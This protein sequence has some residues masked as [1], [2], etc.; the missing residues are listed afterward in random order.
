MLKL[1]SVSFSYEYGSELFSVRTSRSIANDL[2]SLNI[3]TDGNVFSASVKTADEITITDLSAVFEFEFKEEDRIFLNGYQS[4]TD[5]A[6]HPPW[7]GM[8][9]WLRTSQVVADRYAA[10]AH[11]DYS[12][13]KYA[14]RRGEQ[15]GFTFGTFRRGEGMVLVGSLREDHGFTVIRTFAADGRV[16]L[17][18]EMPVRMLDV[19]QRVV[20]GRWAVTRGTLDECYDRWFA[21]M[22]VKARPVRPLVGYTSWY[23]HY[24]DID[25]DKLFHDLEGMKGAPFVERIADEASKAGCS[26][27]MPLFQIDD[28]YC[29]VGDWL[30]VDERK[31]PNGLAPFAR[32]AREAGFLPG[33]WVAPFVCERDSRIFHECGDWL[34]HDDK[35]EPVRSGP[36][37][38]G[39][40]ALDTRNVEVRSYILDVL[41]TMTR[42]WGFG[43]LKID[44]LYAACL[45]TYPGRTRAQVASDA[46]AFLRDCLGDKLILG[47][48]APLFPAAG[49]FDY[50][51]VGPD[52]SLKFDDAWFMRFMHRERVSTKI[53]LQ[54][55]VYRS[56]FDGVL[57]GCDPDVFLL[58]DDN[59]SLSFDRRTALITLNALFG[60]LLM[61]SDNIAD[62]DGEKLDLLTR[63][64]SLF[65]GARVKCYRR[66]GDTIRITYAHAGRDDVIVYDTR[67]GVLI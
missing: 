41:R 6:E 38:S 63:A 36:Q 46:F 40:Y 25:E 2:V 61:T 52:V 24:N 57:F 10:D 43:L 47:C 1:R 33:L 31:F 55:T 27:A 58:R 5:T 23:R 16:T 18:P 30:A 4:W 35:G 8:R 59:L 20:L 14:K 17:K 28:G 29:K 21:L 7:Y 62:Y 50:M 37:W 56:L 34:L 11:G 39:G 66:E 32:A 64:L 54:N 44:F 42:E 22:G 53:T 13:V 19:G 3:S 49:K 26:G 15:H 48:G 67:K 51:R 60:R 12:M 65:R 45:P 9:E